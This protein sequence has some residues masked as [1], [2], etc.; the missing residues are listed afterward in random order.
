MTPLHTLKFNNRFAQL[1]EVFFTKQAA[2]PLPEPYLVD[3]SESCA[4]LLGID[5]QACFKPEF[6][7]YIVGNLPIPNTDPLAQIY[8]GHQFGSYNPRL[9]DGRGLLLGEI[10][11]PS[12]HW[13][14]HLKGAGMTPYSRMGDGRAVLR[15]SIREYLISEAMAGLGIDN[16]YVDLRADEVPIM[17]GSSGPFVFLLQ[18]AGIIEQNKAKG[19]IKITTT[20]IAISTK[21]EILL[22]LQENT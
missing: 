16:A 2:Q 3:V 18:S 10:D 21:K 11:T 17:Y 9:G 19:F 4:A 1:D 15:S 12:G 20:I 14:L 6:A 8:S 7:D 5:Y 13:E 22:F